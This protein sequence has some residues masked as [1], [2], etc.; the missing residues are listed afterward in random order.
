MLILLNTILIAGT[1]L[2]LIP[3]VVFCLECLAALLPWRPRTVLNDAEEAS[4][5]VLLPAHNESSVIARTLDVLMPTLGKHDRAVVIADNCSDDTAEIARS[6]GA[7]AVE[8]TNLEQRGKGYALDFGVKQLHENPPD[9][10]MILD[11]DCN[12][13][14]ATVRTL[15]QLAHQ[16]GRPVQSLNLGEL[17]DRPD[18]MFVAS[19]L[20]NYFINLVRPLGLKKVGLSYRL[21]GTGMALPW[22]IIKDA[23]LASGHIVEDTRLGVDLAIDGHLPIFCPDV[24]VLSR[25]PQQK[26]SFV[27]QRTRWEHGHM[28]AAFSQVP[29]LIQAAI[30]NR[31]L[32]LFWLAMDIAVPPFSL[33][34]F[35]WMLATVATGIAGFCGASLLPFWALCITGVCLVTL[36][37]LN[38]FVYCRKIIPLSVLVGI[39]KYVFKKLPIYFSFLFK[40]QQ[41]WVRT[42]REAEQQKPLA[43]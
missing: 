12:V 8:R 28:Q 32:S 14:P 9:V 36:I 2:L 10:V 27:S 24:R 31:S 39:P 40:R 38:W 18:S 1:V 37:G 16:T 22:S 23:P 29:R 4:V 19:S 42:D 34:I 7:I 21:L 35:L 43:Q 33:M 20:G 13:D 3:F 6:K 30:W 5:A 26:A 15:G 11:A 25:L 17:D 41:E